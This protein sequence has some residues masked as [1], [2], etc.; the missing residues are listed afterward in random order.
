[1]KKRQLCG[2]VSP[3]CSLV[4]RLMWPWGVFGEFLII[5]GDSAYWKILICL[6]PRCIS[7]FQIPISSSNWA[8][9]LSC[10][11]LNSVKSP[12]EIYKDDVLNTCRVL[13]SINCRMYVRP[14]KFLCKAFSGCSCIQSKLTVEWRGTFGILEWP[15]QRGGAQK[16]I[17]VRNF[18]AQL[19]LTN[20]PGRSSLVQIYLRTFMW[21]D[22]RVLLLAFQSSTRE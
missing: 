17:A 14:G 18:A 5:L 6:R 15:Y 2:R 11:L 8:Q 9:V 16:T 4:G 21:M 13:Y 22:V 10:N 1:M 20:N 3:G 19:N 7:R 12:I